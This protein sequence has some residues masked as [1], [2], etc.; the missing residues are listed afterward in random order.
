[1][2]GCSQPLR[3]RTL[4]KHMAMNLLPKWSSCPTAWGGDV[5]GFEICKKAQRMQNGP[6]TSVM[7]SLTM[8]HGLQ[9]IACMYASH[10]LN[11]SSRRLFLWSSTVCKRT[12][13]SLN[14]CCRP[15]NFFVIIINSTLTWKKHQMQ[16]QC[17]LSLFFFGIIPKPK[18]AAS[19]AHGEA[20]CLWTAWS[21][22]AR[23]LFWIDRHCMAVH[24]D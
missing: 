18:R 4:L 5:P 12:F 19:I 24:M 16:Q 21:H 6:H 8:H 3:A 22:A 9:L 1:M 20:L 2:L 10:I 23:C 17:M 7:T 13:C 14:F 11:Y 15:Q